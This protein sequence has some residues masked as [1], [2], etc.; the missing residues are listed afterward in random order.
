MLI[1]DSELYERGIATLLACFDANARGALDARVLR[2]P[3]VTS[4][5]FPVAPER[6]FFNNA[7]L[8]IGMGAAA[9]ARAIRSMEADYAGAGVTEFAAWVHET[10]TDLQA[11]LTDRGYTLNESTLAMG[12]ALDELPAELPPLDLAPPDWD[13]YARLLELPGFLAQGGH[14]AFH[15]QIARLDGES[16][17]QA[18]AFD[19]EGDTGIFNVGT[20]EH[21]RRRGLSSALMAHALRDA[22]SR[23]S[24]TATLQST[25]MAE[26]VYASVGFRPL[27]R[28]LE[29][30]PASNP[31][32]G[33]SCPV[34]IPNF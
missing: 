1:S 20:A 25:P 6:E 34:D 12:M 23:G 33:G 7:V 31:A 9:R 22:A 5:V 14:D 15:V 29:F 26:G 17:A 21:A 27:A 11:E 19:H 16:V 10:D 8:E 32:A 28:I 13:E 18:M 24:T 4:A 2:S 3:G 30:V